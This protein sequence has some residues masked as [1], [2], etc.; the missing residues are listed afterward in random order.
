MVEY[1]ADV[2]REIESDSGTIAGILSHLAE[3][4]L[5]CYEFSNDLKTGFKASMTHLSRS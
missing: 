2:D 1:K 5:T 3:P 4:T